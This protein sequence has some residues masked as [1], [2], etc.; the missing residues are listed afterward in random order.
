MKKRLLIILAAAVILLSA[1]GCNK[2][3]TAD[4]LLGTWRSED[5]YTVEFAGR[6]MTLYNA[7]GELVEGFPA[8]Y[9]VQGNILNV[10]TSEGFVRMFECRV[11]GDSLKLIYTD[12]FLET[13]LGTS[14]KSYSISLTRCED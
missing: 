4:N 8:T 3:S 6:T 7:E 12:D 13:A 5:G 14:E 10:L 1:V 2:L 11:D 9:A